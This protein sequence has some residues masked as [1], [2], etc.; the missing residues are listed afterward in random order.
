VSPSLP[1]PD[2]DRPTSDAQSVAVAA[3]R[4]TLPHTMQ[5]LEDG[6]RRGWHPG[7]QLYVSVDLAPVVDVGLGWARHDV[8]MTAAT[9]LPW[10]CC[11]KPLIAAGFLVLWQDGRV[12]LD[13]PVASIVPEM[14]DGGKHCV[15]F[16][17]LLT[18]TGGLRP[19]PTYRTLWGTRAQSLTSIAEATMPDGVEPGREAYYAQFWG[20]GLLAEAIERLTGA[21]YDDHIRERVLAPLGSPD[22]FF[23][24]PPTEFE[25]A[26]PVLG[27]IFDVDS[28]LAPCVFPYMCEQPQFDT[29]APGAAGGGPMR[30]LGR[31]MEALLP[32]DDVL[33][34]DTARSSITSRHRV[35]LYDAHW[36]SYLSWGLGVIVDGWYFGSSCSPA[37]FGHAG[38]NTSF[39][40]ADP[41]RRLVVACLC[42]GMTDAKR[43]V[44]RDRGIADA[45]YA[46]L[47]F[48]DTAPAPEIVDVDPKPADDA[49]QAM[50]RTEARYWKP[51]YQADL[52]SMAATLGNDLDDPLTVDH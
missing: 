25:A 6:Q 33:F 41:N 11:I 48:D 46:D 21:R 35:G 45:I 18:H 4:R 12:E 23:L 2:I 14:R 8:E 34:R 42:N 24:L 43:S 51:R 32:G 3:A 10:F 26:W 5:V 29:W 17:H 22:A 31:V 1:Y 38:V 47:G 27:L 50:A 40:F 36:R 19:D 30:T 7:A 20:W 28:E 39:C 9:M 49:K 15:T 13:Q 16:R 44:A 52:S 37:T